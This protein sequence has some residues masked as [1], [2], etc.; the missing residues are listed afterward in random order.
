MRILRWTFQILQ[1]GS[2]LCIDIGLVMA[3]SFKNI[4]EFRLHM[5]RIN[6]IFADITVREPYILPVLYV[7]TLTNSGFLTFG[8]DFV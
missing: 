1:R 2:V 5:K 4:P 6:W 3:G 7:L 8:S